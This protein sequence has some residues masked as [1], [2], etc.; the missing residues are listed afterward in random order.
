MAHA[1]SVK[2]Q[3]IATHSDGDA[4][5]GA[6]DT[7]SAPSRATP[8]GQWARAAAR[9][10]ARSSIAPVYRGCCPRKRS[11]TVPF[12][13]RPRS[14]L[15]RRTRSWVDEECPRARGV[16]FSPPRS[17]RAGP[18]A[19]DA[20]CQLGVDRRTRRR[21][22]GVLG[23]TARM[24]R[25]QRPRISHVPPPASAAKCP[26]VPVRL[27]SETLAR[28]NEARPEPGGSNVPQVHES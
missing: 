1:S 13:V 14:L 5:R 27:R 18:Y 19:S 22:A 23:A 25:G 26:H 3:T 15:G 6:A 24:D 11:F 4:P 17:S 20:D 7:S 28:R 9:A 10:F 16:R 2:R 21:A 12:P 8:P